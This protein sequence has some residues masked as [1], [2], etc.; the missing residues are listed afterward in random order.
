[1]SLKQENICQ[2]SGQ[3]I[4]AVKKVQRPNVWI[5]HIV[6]YGCKWQGK[7]ITYDQSGVGFLFLGVFFVFF[8]SDKS[9]TENSI[10]TTLKLSNDDF[11]INCFL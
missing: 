2:K 9:L 1:M 7:T 11:I 10:E 8:F 5:H 4:P 6:A 3:V